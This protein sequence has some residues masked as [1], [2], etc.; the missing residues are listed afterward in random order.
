MGYQRPM[1]NVWDFYELVF[2]IVDCLRAPFVQSA[3]KVLMGPHNH[4]CDYE[5]QIVPNKP[6]S[7]F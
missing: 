7:Y 1:R 4:L 2:I 3:L 6:Q 5:G